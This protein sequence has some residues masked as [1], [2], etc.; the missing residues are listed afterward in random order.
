MMY[1]TFFSQAINALENNMHVSLGR[2]VR[3][4][5]LS[6]LCGEGM[7]GV[8]VYDACG[9]LKLTNNYCTVQLVNSII[10]CGI[11]II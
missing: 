9:C 6:C 7:A 2:H 5:V 1:L 8:R 3:V 4:C 10:L 11:F